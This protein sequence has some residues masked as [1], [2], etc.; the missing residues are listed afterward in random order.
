MDISAD[1]ECV[2]NERMPYCLMEMKIINLQ[3]DEFQDTQKTKSEKNI[4]PE[5]YCRN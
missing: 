1:V 4:L 2:R 3:R 5:F